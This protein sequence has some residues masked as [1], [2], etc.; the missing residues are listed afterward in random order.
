MKFHILKKNVVSNYSTY[1]KFLNFLFFHKFNFLLSIFFF[2]L[3]D[4]EDL[5]DELNMDFI[6]KMPKMTPQQIGSCWR[7]KV[8]RYV[9]KG[10]KLRSKNMHLYTADNEVKKYDDPL[11]SK[12]LFIIFFLYS[13]FFLIFVIY[14]MS[15][16]TIF[17]QL[18]RRFTT[19]G[20]RFIRRNWLVFL[21][22]T[23]CM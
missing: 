2:F 22:L 14:Y 10:F 17:M 11:Q 20:C 23:V 5:S 7:K 18:F 13:L 12:D 4:I 21:E 9:T 1:L 8:P 16:H 19:L 3:Q 6:V 15:L